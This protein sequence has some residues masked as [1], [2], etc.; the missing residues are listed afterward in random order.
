MSESESARVG[1]L[2]R[3][4]QWRRSR[5]ARAAERAAARREQ[6]LPRSSAGHG[7]DKPGAGGGYS[8]GY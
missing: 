4:R 1:V 5:K 8:G 7:G 2:E 6:K 3:L